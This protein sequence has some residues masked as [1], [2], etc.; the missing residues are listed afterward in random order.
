VCEIAVVTSFSYHHVESVDGTRIGFRHGGNGPALV[1]VHGG[2]LASQHLIAL[3]TALASDFEVVIPDRR[4]RGE[5]GSSRQGSERVIDQQA[6][7]IRAVIDEVAARGVFGLSV[8]AIVTLN[9]VQAMETVGKIALYEPPLSIAGSSPVE[10]IG[11][12]D[13]E[14]AAGNP[15]GALITAMHGMKVDAIMSRIPHAAAPLLRI[16]F[17]AEHTAPGDV[18]VLDLVPTLHHDIQIIKETADTVSDYS[19]IRAD[20]LLLGGSKSPAYLA[21]SL[22]ALQAALPNP[23]RITLSGLDHQAPVDKPDKIAPILRDFFT[24]IP[25]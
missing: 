1:L 16:L 6:A 20:V 3:G 21:R 7:D 24:E 5:S 8:G 10:W 22:D 14:M 17:R 9:A 2:M 23:R 11:R 12:F 19:S 13:R 25:N 15:A 4:G 18:P